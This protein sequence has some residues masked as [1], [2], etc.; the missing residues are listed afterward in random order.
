LPCYSI[1]SAAPIVDL[2]SKVVAETTGEPARLSPM[3]GTADA[4]YFADRQIPAVYYG[5]A[6]G[7]M[8]SPDE[9]VDLASVRRVAHVLANTIVRWCTT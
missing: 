9:W 5:P 6:G 8:H 7:G 1:E 2:L 4:R 3:F